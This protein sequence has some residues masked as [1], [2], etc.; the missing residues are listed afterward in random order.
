MSSTETKRSRDST[1]TTDTTVNVN[2]ILDAAHENFTKLVNESARIQ[3]QYAQAVSNL[4]Q[5][6]MDAIKSAIQTT[7][8]VQKQVAS[9]NTSFN[10]FIASDTAATPYVQGIVRQSSEMTNNV[11]RIADINNQLAINALNVLR[12]NVRNYSKTVEAAAE[13][14]SNLANA[15]A[16]S[17]SSFQQQF[18]ANR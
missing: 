16:S 15:W 13:Y 7:T 18:T 5:E 6:Y 12:E 10:N 9:S 2:Q 11:I 8:S 3:P 1:A 14:N 4:Q 17:Y